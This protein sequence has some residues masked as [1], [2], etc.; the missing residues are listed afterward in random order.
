MA[1]TLLK[2]KTEDNYSLVQYLLSKMNSF[3]YKHTKCDSGRS[4]IHSLHTVSYNTFQ[5][6]SGVY[7]F[8]NKLFN[9][10]SLKGVFSG[11][12]TN[13]TGPVSYTHLD[14]YKRQV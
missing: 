14:V 7:H 9:Y 1:C 5:R 11:E 12:G 8:L 2:Y 6:F 13:G 3:F 10:F 4:L